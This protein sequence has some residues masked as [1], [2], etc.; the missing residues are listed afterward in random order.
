ME[1]RSRGRRV[2]AAVFATL[3]LLSALG[4]GAPGASHLGHPGSSAPTASEVPPPRA[5]TSGV[6]LLVDPSDWTTF[7]GQTTVFSALWAAAPPGCALTPLWYR[8]S[9]S[10]GGSV[11]A[12]APIDGNST[13]FTATTFVAGVA[14]LLVRAAATL[15]CGPSE[16]LLD[17]VGSAN[18]TVVAPIEVTELGVE[19]HAIAANGTTNLSGWVDGGV[20]PYRFSVA[21]GDGSRTDSNVSATG[22]FSFLHRFPAGEFVPSVTVTDSTAQRANASVGEPVY[23]SSGL[24][25]G[26][27]PS[28]RVA[29]AG[30]PIEL[31]GEIVHPPP[32]YGYATV[33]TDSN[34]TP[35]RPPVESGATPPVF[36]CTFSDPGTALVEL[37]VVPTSSA[38]P[39]TALLAEPVVADVA[40][41]LGVTSST[42][43]TGSWARLT[44]NLSGGVAP[45]ALTWQLSGSAN[46]SSVTVERDGTVSLP[47]ISSA[48][49]VFTVAVTVTDSVGLVA[50]NT[51]API[52]FV[53][54]LE[55]M[56]ALGRVSVSNGTLVEVTG[57][58]AGGA[59]PYSWAVVPSLVPAGCSPG[60]GSLGSPAGFAWNGTFPQE[61][62]VSVAVAVVDATGSTWAGGFDAALVTPL[63]VLATLTATETANTS[64]LELTVRIDGGLGPFEGT[65]TASR[66]VG[67]TNF[68]V[69]QDG[70]STYRFSGNGTGTFDLVLT[71]LDRLGD[72]VATN[73][74]ATTPTPPPPPP[75]PNFPAPPTPS[76]GLGF[77]ETA[78]SIGGFAAAFAAA[79]VWVRFRRKARSPA[80]P[81]PTPDPVAVIRQIVEP[82]DGVDRSTVELLAE[83]AGVPL[84]AVRETIDRLVSAGR[85]RRGVEPDG[86]EVLAWSEP[87]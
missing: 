22:P 25:V 73:L 28:T 65:V 38:P 41:S 77:E 37:D 51:S 84:E 82:A 55:A 2:R 83:E 10:L 23:A 72:R 33:C 70:D 19:P 49:G 44:A 75:S 76:V 16:A 63:R 3:T 12:L 27:R 61:G 26:V 79:L 71:V 14:T 58:V 66:E 8:W 86:E 68:S 35:G 4:G 6:E 21:W 62:N 46:A 78:V 29:E 47:V 87:G 53:P 50:T 13:A 69:P 34:G 31:T 18:V 1:T 11:G 56:A 20:P 36:T 80:N 40:L 7:V 81:A 64:L 5:S 24:A 60:N 9:Q 17:L 57:T 39:A 48:A 45:F 52:R 54:A 67:W 59:A 74:S 42:T 15:V 85:L 32:A 30:A 43:D